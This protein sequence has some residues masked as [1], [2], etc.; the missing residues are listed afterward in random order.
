MSTPIE[1]DIATQLAAKAFQPYGC[2]TRCNDADSSFGFSVKNS[3]GTEVLNIPHI[4]R[5]QYADPMRLMGVIEQARLDLEHKGCH[6]DPWSMPYILD[7]SG[8]PE[9]PPNY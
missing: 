3:Q 7:P 4:P 9:T 6:L 2:V 5:T 1:L 8:I